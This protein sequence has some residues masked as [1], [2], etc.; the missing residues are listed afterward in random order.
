MDKTNR[1]LAVEDYRSKKDGLDLSDLA[2]YADTI[3]GCR[4][5]IEDKVKNS[6]FSKADAETAVRTGVPY[7]QLHPEKI[8]PEQFR[9]ACVYLNQAFVD[10]GIHVCPSHK[11]IAQSFKWDKLTDE[12]IAL[13]GVR[14]NDFFMA[15]SEEV[16]DS[17]DPSADMVLAGVLISVVR[18]FLDGIGEEMTY[19][20]SRQDEVKFKD[21]PML[22]PTCGE[23]PA[24]SSVLEGSDSSG[25]ARRL[26][27]YCCGTSWPFERV[28]CARCGSRN[29]NKLRYIHLEQDVAHRLHVCDN[30]GEYIPTVFQEALNKTFD[31]DVEQTVSGFAES[32][33]LGDKLEEFK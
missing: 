33:Y 7:L 14:P 13:A 30:C 27:C 16:I 3:L 31:F 21:L 5:V 19:Y 29:S 25:S 28:R 23:A 26:F 15:A 12:T 9:Q 20:L 1:R 32:V 8:D 17:D 10:K 6:E 24:L 22:C 11:E 4:D 18:A 2:K